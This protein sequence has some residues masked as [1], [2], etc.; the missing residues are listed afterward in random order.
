MITQFKIIILKQLHPPPL[1]HIKLFLIKDVL[2]T[3]MIRKD[4]KPYSVQVVSPNLQCKQSPL[5]PGHEL[6][7]S[8]H[9][10]LADAMRKPPHSGVAST[11]N[12]NPSV[13][14]HN[15]LQAVH[16]VPVRLEQVLKLTFASKSE[17]LLHT[18]TSKQKALPFLP[19]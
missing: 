2:E 13:T 12:P 5:I 11:R 16:A 18:T 10:I 19:T 9:A 4:A 3:L 17:N 7:S 14:H 8:P 15:T 1:T 6:G